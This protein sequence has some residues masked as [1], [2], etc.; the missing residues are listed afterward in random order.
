[1]DL[2]MLSTLAP[3]SDASRGLAQLI[4]RRRQAVAAVAATEQAQG[5]AHEDARDASD[6]VAQ[7]EAALGDEPPPA[8]RK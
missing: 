7:M 5:E 1:M 2:T 4:E 6:A 3:T 8:E